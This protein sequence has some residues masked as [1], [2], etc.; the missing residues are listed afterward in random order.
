MG[1]NHQPCQYQVDLNMAMA[2]NL[3]PPGNEKINHTTIWLAAEILFVSTTWV[4]P[5]DW[6]DLTNFICGWVDWLCL[7]LSEL[8]IELHRRLP[9]ISNRLPYASIHLHD[10]KRYTMCLCYFIL[11]PW[12]PTLPWR[13]LAQALD[14]GPTAAPGFTSLQ[15]SVFETLTA[16]RLTMKAKVAP[17]LGSTYIVRFFVTSYVELTYITRNGTM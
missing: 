13:P 1:W 3:P 17:K 6:S 14:H 11:S 5:G 4:I 8:T 2:L 9:L 7:N 15:R 12:Y 10:V 16:S